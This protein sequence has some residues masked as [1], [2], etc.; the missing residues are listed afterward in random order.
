[1]KYEKLGEQW[2]T[3]YLYGFLTCRKILRHVIDGFTSPPKEVVLHILTLLEIHCRR[4]GLNPQ[5]LGPKAQVTLYPKFV[6]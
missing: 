2:P 5:T 1:M 4:P 3:K 6:I